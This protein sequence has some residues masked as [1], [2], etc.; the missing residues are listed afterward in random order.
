MKK[1]KLF[2]MT[3]LLAVGGLAMTS[4]ENKD[5][6]KVCDAALK[7]VVFKDTVVSKTQID[8]FA[9][10]PVN[11][12]GV[13]TKIDIKWSATPEDRFEFRY[14]EETCFATVKLPDATKNEESVSF[15]LTASATYKSATSTKEFTGTLLPITPVVDNTISIA[16]AMAKPDATVVT[17][18]GVVTN[19]RS[20]KGFFITDKT[21]T[22]YVY[23]S[24][25]SAGI[26]STAMPYGCTV[27][28]TATKSVMN[29]TY[30]Y[31]PELV[32]DETAQVELVSKTVTNI[33]TDSAVDLT[34]T[35]F[36]AWDKENKDQY[37]N[38]V[39]KVHG[40]VTIYDGGSYQKYEVVDD[41]G[42]YIDFY[43]TDGSVYANEV[44][45]DKTYDV[46]MTVYDYQ[47][48]KTKFRMSPLYFAPAA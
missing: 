4:C 46:Y 32:Y 31:A 21:G 47:V 16:D 42:G 1:F 9:K 38:K 10:M 29:G 3:A 39:Y 17:V 18:S 43:A 28:L 40:K 5:D 20:G 14:E 37:F 19:A 11:I 6:K 25:N 7:Y 44:E 2:A 48:S 22:A 36:K 41:A 27:K 13:E 26:G 34:V 15:T 24:K 33:P 12:D 8:L 23:D 45:A 35:E 30:S